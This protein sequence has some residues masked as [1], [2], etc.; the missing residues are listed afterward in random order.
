MSTITCGGCGEVFEF[1]QDYS[2]EQHLVG[3]WDC[4]N[5]VVTCEACGGAFE[6]MIY[7]K[8]LARPN[9]TCVPDELLASTEWENIPGE[10][11]PAY[12][13]RDGV[14][15]EIHRLGMVARALYATGE[16]G[17]ERRRQVTPDAVIQQMVSEWILADAG[18]EAEPPPNSGA[19]T[20]HVIG[21]GVETYTSGGAA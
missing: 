21:W 16:D 17:R 3:N 15:R 9:R 12:E 8:H 6:Q 7:V 18:L 1:G 4:R 19:G 2:F 13:L 14:W 11:L 5:T 10:R 20:S